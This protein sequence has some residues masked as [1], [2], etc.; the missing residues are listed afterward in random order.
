MQ[1]VKHGGTNAAH[2]VGGNCRA[3]PR[4]ADHEA[5]FRVARDDQSGQRPRDVGKIDRVRAVGANILNLVTP[6]GS[7]VFRDNLL[8][9]EASVVGSYDKAQQS[10]P[11][12]QTLGKGPY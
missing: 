8:Q 12:E 6:A 7:E 9:L 1:V 4:S 3:D 5:A 10:A 11:G 2:F